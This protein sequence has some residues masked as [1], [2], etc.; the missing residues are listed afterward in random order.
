MLPLF[1]PR[2]KPAEAEAGTT[3]QISCFSWCFWESENKEQEKTRD[4]S[5]SAK[6]RQGSAEDTSVLQMGNERPPTDQ[7]QRG[8]R[9][10]FQSMSGGRHM[11][12][13]F[14][15][16]SGFLMGLSYLNHCKNQCENNFYVEV[17]GVKESIVIIF[18]VKVL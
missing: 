2:I 12:L 11:T 7:V 16:P 3:N 4:G 14:W 1:L 9:I 5:E 8:E 13:S 10:E 6:D 15:F 18:I 17:M